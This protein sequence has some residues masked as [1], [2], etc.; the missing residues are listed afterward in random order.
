MV[1]TEC[2][3]DESNKSE[4]EQPSSVKPQLFGRTLPALPND[5]VVDGEGQVSGSSSNSDSFCSDE[6][7][8]EEERLFNQK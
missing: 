1:K 5:N 6:E 4:T 2:F 3:L 7:D 8:S